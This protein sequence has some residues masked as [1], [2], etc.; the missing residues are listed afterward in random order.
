MRKL[1][2][3]K[4]A[5][6]SGDGG[7]LYA[8]NIG[9]EVK[10]A[11]VVIKKSTAAD[12]GG[13]YSAALVILDRS[14]VLGNLASGSGGALFLPAVSGANPAGAF[15]RRST[16]SA[17]E[18]VGLGGGVALDGFDAGGFPAEP[19]ADIDNSTIGANRADV[20]GGGVSAIFGSAAAI[21]NTTIALN[22]SDAGRFERGE[23]RRHLPV[24]Q[25]DLLS[26][27]LD[28]RQQRRRHHRE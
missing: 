22:R 5:A 2:L 10:L 4:G 1:T 7:A 18:A 12:G 11:N 9:G 23:R 13:I 3:A 26:R 17:N 28:P 16:I 25:R 8:G 21:D 27:R 19:F 6:G 24:I 14:T 20:S 15:I